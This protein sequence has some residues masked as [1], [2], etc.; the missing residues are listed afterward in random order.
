MDLLE[1]GGLLEKGVYK[2]K[3]LLEM[4]NLLEKGAY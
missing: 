2:R 3:G 1:M 4:G